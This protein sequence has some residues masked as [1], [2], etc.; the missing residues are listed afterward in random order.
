[1]PQY[2]HLELLS[3]GP[4]LRVRV[5]DHR[6]YSADEVAALTNEW[7]SVADRDDCQTLFLDC[8]NVVVLSSEMLSKLVMLRRRL[9]QKEANLVLAGVRAEVREV[10]VGP[11]STGSS[12]SRTTRK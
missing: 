2:R 4:V 12:R 10:R 1:M 9:K 8:S 11:S 6:P 7:N 5:L 3:D